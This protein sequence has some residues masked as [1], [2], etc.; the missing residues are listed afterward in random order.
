MEK[1]KKIFSPLSIDKRS[2]QF[3][4]LRIQNNDN[5]LKIDSQW[6]SMS[7]PQIFFFFF[8]ETIDFIEVKHLLQIVLCKLQQ[9]K[10]TF[11]Y[12]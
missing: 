8:F 10:M 1:K 4:E 6:S 2:Q 11:G 12:L 3:R 7:A 5:S 9:M